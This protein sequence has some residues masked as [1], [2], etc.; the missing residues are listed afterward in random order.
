MSVSKTS[1]RLSLSAGMRRVGVSKQWTSCP[2][3]RSMVEQSWSWSTS[4]SSRATR[5]DFRRVGAAFASGASSRATSNVNVLPS[6]SRLSTWMSP[7]R[8]C[9]FLRVMASPSPNPSSPWA[10]LMR[11]NSPKRR[12]CSAV[13]M[14]RPV[15]LTLTVSRPSRAVTRSVTPPFEVNLMAFERRFSVICR[16]RR[17]SPEACTVTMSAA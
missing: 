5:S 13:G 9:A 11:E 1:K 4:S 16:S 14:P 7:P 15:S 3:L 8:S 6:P 12:S 2:S 10:L 17:G